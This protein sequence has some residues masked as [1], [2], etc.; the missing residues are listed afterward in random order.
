MRSITNSTTQKQIKGCSQ[1]SSSLSSILAA[2]V[3]GIMSAIRTNTASLQKKRGNMSNTFERVLVEGQCF[4]CAKIN[5][6][7]RLITATRQKGDTERDLVEKAGLC[8]DCLLYRESKFGKNLLS[9]PDTI[10]Q[11]LV[12]LINNEASKIKKGKW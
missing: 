2:S 1:S 10:G 6:G 12:D 9:S 3:S 11:S 5:S 4:L 8:D 7:V